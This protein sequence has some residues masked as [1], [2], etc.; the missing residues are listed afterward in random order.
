MLVGDAELD[1]GTN[2]EAIAFARAAGLG[3][4]TV[5]VIDNQSSTHGWPG[6]IAA[7]FAVEGWLT[8][9]VDGRDHDALETALRE[10]HPERPSVVVAVVGAKR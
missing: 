1:E 8:H 7:R 9:E 4:L 2:A 3:R 10:T 5:V 6:G